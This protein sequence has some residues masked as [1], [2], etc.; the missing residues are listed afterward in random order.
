MAAVLSDTELDALDRMAGYAEPAAEAEEAAEYASLML[1][2][3]LTER[4]LS[5]KMAAK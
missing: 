5:G 1:A 4:F 2:E 3:Y